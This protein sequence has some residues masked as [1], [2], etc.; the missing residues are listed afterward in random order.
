MFENIPEDQRACVLVS[1]AVQRVWSK[2]MDLSAMVARGHRD[3]VSRDG[4]EDPILSWCNLEL[5]L[6]DAKGAPPSTQ[7]VSTHRDLV[8]T[9]LF[10]W[11]KVPG[12]L[13]G[14]VMRAAEE[15][16]VLNG[17]DPDEG[18]MTA[19]LLMQNA[20]GAGEALS[21]RLA[22]NKAKADKRRRTKEVEQLERLRLRLGSEVGLTA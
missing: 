15:I 20:R 6:H 5:A 14:L 3:L 12:D 21:E 17:R 4:N 16:A 2:R 9:V 19:S 10:V 22:D 11:Y 13:Q 8:E 1:K 7:S 18:L